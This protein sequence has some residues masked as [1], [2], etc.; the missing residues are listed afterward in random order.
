MSRSGVG[1]GQRP[2]RRVCGQPD[3]HGRG[4][5]RT[6]TGENLEEG[7]GAG[8]ATSPSCR[9]RM[10]IRTLT[11]AREPV[12]V[13]RGE[14]MARCG[15]S[16]NVCPHR[17][18]LIVRSPAGSFKVG[19]PVRQSEADDL[20]VPRLAVRHAG[21][22]ASRFRARAQGYQDRLEPASRARLRELPCTVGLRRLRLGQPR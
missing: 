9:S 8:A 1:W 10:T 2:G 17:G 20:H 14:D 22:D 13:C 4:A 6:G 21:A 16:S 3:L 12:I 7:L 5:L 15:P 18:N 11:I 19:R